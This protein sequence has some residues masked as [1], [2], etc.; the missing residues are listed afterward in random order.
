MYRSVSSHVRARAADL[1]FSL[2]YSSIA[3]LSGYFASE[4]TRNLEMV[5][6]WDCQDFDQYYFL[7]KREILLNEG[8][9]E[10][11]WMPF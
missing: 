3:S 5:N 6:L 1:Y 8:K 7:Q 11:N 4:I 10:S 9:C 2:N